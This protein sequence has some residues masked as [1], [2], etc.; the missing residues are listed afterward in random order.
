MWDFISF[1]RD[2]P[3]FFFKGRDI[4][5]TGYT[6]LEYGYLFCTGTYIKVHTNITQL[7]SHKKLVRFEWSRKSCEM[8][9]FISFSISAPIILRS[10]GHKPKSTH[11]PGIW[12]LV[13]YNNPF[14]IAHEHHTAH[15]T[16]EASM[17][18]VIPQVLR[19]VRFY[20]NVN[21]RPHF[22]EMGVT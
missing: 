2:T 19:D 14:K 21:Q 7:S 13:L 6:I 20:Q 5:L 11:Y 9:D 3:I 1:S 18:W 10:E 15:F 12:L 17:V 8:W 4:Y 22:F 16:L